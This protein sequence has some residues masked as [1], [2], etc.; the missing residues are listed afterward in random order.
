MDTTLA[1]YP[2]LKSLDQPCL[3]YP[4]RLRVWPCKV[5]SLFPKQPESDLPQ[6]IARMQKLQAE[7]KALMQKKG[8]SQVQLKKHRDVACLNKY[9]ALL[10]A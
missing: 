2:L 1:M 9:K 7:Q 8:D 4:Q 3:P 5:H 6:V 10:K